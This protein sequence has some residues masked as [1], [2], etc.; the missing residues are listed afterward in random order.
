MCRWRR[1]VVSMTEMGWAIVT[2]LLSMKVR[3]GPTHPS[4]CF[5]YRKWYLGRRCPHQEDRW[6]FRDHSQGPTV[7]WLSKR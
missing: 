6:V 2:G 7:G 1:Q 5:R 3:M 4:W